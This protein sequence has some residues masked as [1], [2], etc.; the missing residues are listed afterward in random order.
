MDSAASAA[1]LLFHAARFDGRAP[2]QTF[3]PG[4]L[5]AQL[6]DGLLQGGYLTVQFAQQRFKLCTVQRRMGGGRRHMKHRVDRTEFGARKNEGNPRF[7]PA[8]PM[9]R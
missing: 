9:S 2:F 1:W 5:F 6:G 4:V 8:C 3:Q 7:C